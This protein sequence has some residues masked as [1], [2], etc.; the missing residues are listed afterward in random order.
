[1]VSTARL[2]G[3]GTTLVATYRVVR[4]VQMGIWSIRCPRTF[5]VRG[6]PGHLGVMS[7]TT[8]QRNRAMKKVDTL[9]REYTSKL[10]DDNLRFLD[11]R[12][13]QR[14]S[15]DLP[16]ALSFLAQTNDMDRW[17]SSAKGAIEFYDMVDTLAKYVEREYK[18]RNPR[19]EE[20]RR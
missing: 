5:S 4:Y 1:M 17:L 6:E 18:K 8:Y 14:L 10:S 20:D 11:S 12:L 7:V 9:L 15:G 19:D 13:G 3:T 16:E 2:C